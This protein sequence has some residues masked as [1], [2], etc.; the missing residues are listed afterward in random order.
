[1][2]CDEFPAI[3]ANELQALTD[4]VSSPLST[5]PVSSSLIANYVVPQVI[6]RSPRARSEIFLVVDANRLLQRICQQRTSRMPW[7]RV[8]WASS[9]S[10][11][12]NVIR[13]LVV[14]SCGALN[15]TIDFTAER[16]KVDRLGQERLGAVLEGNPSQ[17][18]LR[19]DRAETAGG[20]G[21]LHPARRRPQG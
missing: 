7:V 4:V 5:P 15:P 11:Q 21:T 14:A 3:S 1:M 17:T 18:D 2:R 6:V 8:S 12:C 10:V 9:G 20:K 19:G 13:T 16:P